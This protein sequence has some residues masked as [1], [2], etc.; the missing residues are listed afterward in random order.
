M[1][2]FT[3]LERLLEPFPQMSSTKKLSKNKRIAFTAITALFVFLVLELVMIVTEPLLFRGFYQYD[4]DLGFKVRPYTNGTNRFGFNDVDHPL[5]KPRDSYRILILGDS[6]NW[7]GG[8][9]NNYVPLIRKKLDRRFGKQKIEVINAG[10][11]MTHTG[12]QLALLKKY[13]LQYKPD[14][15]FL[16]FFA[17]NDYVDADPNRK[18]IVLND[19]M[20]DIDPSM[21]IIIGG[22]PIIPHSRIY[23]YLKQKLKVLVELA[24]TDLFINTANAGVPSPVVLSEF[25]FFRVRQAQMEFFDLRRHQRKEY[26]LKIDFIHQK[27]DEMKQLLA[28]NGIKFAV[29]IYPDQLQ[30]DQMLFDQVLERFRSDFD[31]GQLDRTLPNKILKKH[32]NQIGVDNFDLQEEFASGKRP[33][34][35]YIAKDTHWSLK[36]NQLAAELIYKYLVQQLPAT[37]R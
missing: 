4:P 9:K 18:R 6:F 8:L 33:G 7:A 25:T 2:Y 12:E 5:E 21:E 11:P 32:L 29:G 34:E 24:S 36:G 35:N 16:G 37:F 17:G 28:D 31:S 13:A 19:T 30:V 26:D 14:F 23:H 1:V 3:Y 27:I 20:F 10:Y 15:L 22:Y